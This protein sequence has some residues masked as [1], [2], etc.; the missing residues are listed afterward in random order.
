MKFIKSIFIVFLGG[1]LG[2]LVRYAFALMV[3]STGLFP[4]ST[5]IVNIFG[6]FLMGILF[7]I[8]VN[9]RKR[10]PEGSDDLYRIFG[11]GVL[12]GFTT[13]SLIAFE[14]AS[15]IEA[16][17]IIPALLYGA[18]SVVAGV[19]ACWIGLHLAKTYTREA[20]TRS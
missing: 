3:P 20:R 2:T 16:G 5:F 1:A 4:V 12:G 17:N 6:S 14:N 9:R 7:S 19:I 13:Y 15:L 11:T 10:D 18:G 8:L